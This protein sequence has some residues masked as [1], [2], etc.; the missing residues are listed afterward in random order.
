MLRDMGHVVW[1]PASS[2]RRWKRTDTEHW[3]PTCSVCGGI[4]HA[5]LEPVAFHERPE[6]VLHESL[7]IVDVVHIADR[8]AAELAPSP[9]QG[10]PPALD[11]ERLQRLGMKDEQLQALRADAAQLLGQTRELLKS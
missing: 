5:I 9:F 4:P 6:Q 11:V 1:P 2:G 10:A 3:V 8:I 7:D